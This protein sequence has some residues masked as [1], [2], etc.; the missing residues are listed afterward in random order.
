V[1]EWRVGEVVMQVAE[2][3]GIPPMQDIVF[4]N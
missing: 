4:C 2:E 3:I 1:E